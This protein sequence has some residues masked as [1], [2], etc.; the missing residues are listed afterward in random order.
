MCKGT[1]MFSVYGYQKLLICKE[2]VHVGVFAPFEVEILRRRGLFDPPVAVQPAVSYDVLLLQAGIEV[3]TYVRVGSL[4][5]CQIYREP[6]KE[7]KDQ[8]EK[9]FESVCAVQYAVSFLH[10]RNLK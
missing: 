5:A 10:Y 3:K 4:A 6:L 7:P 8:I 2:H 9:R 1:V